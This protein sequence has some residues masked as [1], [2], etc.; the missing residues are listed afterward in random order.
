MALHIKETIERL[1][2][3]TP[4]PPV[5]STGRGR[6]VGKR[7]I[8]CPYIP[9]DVRRSMAATG[10]KCVIARK[11]KRIVYMVDE[12]KVITAVIK[13]RPGMSDEEFEELCK[14]LTEKPGIQKSSE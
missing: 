12:N 8:G 11:D 10:N 2:K 6:T 3:A 14:F 4:T 13:G 7:L 1:K 5:G 9:A